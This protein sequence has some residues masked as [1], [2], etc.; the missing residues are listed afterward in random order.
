[1]TMVNPLAAQPGEDPL[2]GGIFLPGPKGRH[3]PTS[4]R[5]R[6]AS[7]V[8]RSG[9]PRECA[10]PPVYRGHLPTIHAADP[11]MLSTPRGS[12]RTK[13]RHVVQMRL[14]TLRLVQ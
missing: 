11:K 1:M 3:A 7:C 4:T 5:V 10:P 6:L 9:D 8:C 12:I 14:L 13:R 2:E